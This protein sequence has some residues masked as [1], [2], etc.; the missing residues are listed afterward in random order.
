MS[1]IYVKIADIAGEC[2]N[3][4]FED[5][6]ECV[7]MRHAIAHEVLSTGARK[8][9]NSRHGA[10]ELTHAIDKATPLLHEAVAGAN[11]KG[12][13]TITRTGSAGIA[14]VITLSNVYIVRVDVDTPV[15]TDTLLPD[16]EDA[17]ETFALEYS[18]IKWEYKWYDGDNERGTVS[19]GWNTQTLVTV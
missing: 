11:N 10:I 18:Q 7:S 12:E 13:V 1:N 3:A 6:I 5:Q 2:R 19:G 9:G 8:V 15:D 16:D 4:N 17:L 14:E